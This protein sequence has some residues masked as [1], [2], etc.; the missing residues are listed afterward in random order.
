MSKGGPVKGKLYTPAE[1][2]ASEGKIAQLEA[3]I[4]SLKVQMQNMEN[5]IEALEH[6]IYAEESSI[7]EVDELEAAHL[8][9]A[10]LVRARREG[11]A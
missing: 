5:S 6:I 9:F 11:S 8:Q 10:G 3:E 4:N 2:G 1:M 7:D